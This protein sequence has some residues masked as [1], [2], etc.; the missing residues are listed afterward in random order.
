MATV[1]DEARGFCIHTPGASVVDLGTQFGVSVDA[2][3][4]ADVHVLAGRVDVASPGQPTQ[5]IFA[6]HAVRAVSVTGQVKV[7]PIAYQP[8]LFVQS[9]RGG[10]RWVPVS[11]DAYVHSAS[12]GTNFGSQPRLVVQSIGRT[13]DTMWVG[14]LRF[15]LPTDASQVKSA[16]VRL[17]VS[18]N[19]DTGTG[20]GSHH[21]V[22]V[23]GLND[24]RAGRRWAERTLAWRNAPALLPDGKYSTLGRIDE[25]R[26]V[27][28]GRFMVPSAA[29]PGTAPPPQCVFTAPALSDFL[30]EQF[31]LGQPAL[32]TSVTLILVREAPRSETENL[33][34]YTK[35]CGDQALAPAMDL[36]LDGVAPAP[37]RA[38][39]SE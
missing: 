38:T 29:M 12:P 16:R 1:P 37:D 3:G 26:V 4:T 33:G 13:F 39:K 6:G 17:C 24:D 22:S 8:G 34:F 7:A 27:P 35:E 18:E 20:H 19:I 31:R 36:I 14:Y 10:S 25:T 28:L 23:F 30:N 32:R 21:T 5:R 15:D 2:S 9:L 11:A